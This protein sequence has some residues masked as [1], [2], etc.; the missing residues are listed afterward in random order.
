M[1][2]LTKLAEISLAV[3]T[4]NQSKLL[5]IFLENYLRSAPPNIDLIIIDDGST[6]ATGD[7]LRLLD[8]DARI[9]THRLPHSSI[10]R[11][12]NHALQNSTTPWLAFSDTD[13]L[14]DQDYFKILAGLPARFQG[15]IAIEGAVFPPLESKRPFTHSMANP[16]GGTY[17]TA[18]MVFHVP[19]ILGMGGFDE[20]FHNYREDSDLALTIL[21]KSGP[22][23]FCPE[24]AI[25][26]PH[27]TRKMGRALQRA[28]AIQ[29]Q[30]IRSE[31]LLFKKHPETYAKVRYYADARS[32][33]LAWCFK[34]SIPY[35]KEAVQYLFSTRNLNF[36]SRL[37]GLKLGITGFIVALWEQMCIGAICM[38][39]W[40]QIKRLKSK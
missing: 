38:L 5:K 34:Y 29:Y 32:T 2:G 36:Y 37:Q 15:S 21:E 35:L 18:N 33:I 16:K 11:A 1:L 20:R 25:V 3:V 30:I 26:H 28:Y 31:K 13:C 7:V 8:N 24:L 4:F 10:A 39:Q 27:L 23:P 9:H 19:S 17:A 22:I 12:R 40:D 6:D 14:L